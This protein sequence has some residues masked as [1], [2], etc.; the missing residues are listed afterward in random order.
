MRL[1]T[2]YGKADVST[3][4]TYGRPARVRRLRI[5]ESAFEGRPNTL[6]AA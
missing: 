6:L 3:Y 1:E 5:P 4:R 2:H